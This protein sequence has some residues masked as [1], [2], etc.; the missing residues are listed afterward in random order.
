MKNILPLWII[1]FT[2]ELCGRGLWTIITCFGIS[3]NFDYLF[4]IL[5]IIFY[6]NDLKLNLSRGYTKW[7]KS[8]R[9]R[10]ISF[11][12]YVE[13]NKKWYKWSYL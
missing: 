9:E 13:S 1:F 6:V 12:L 4:Q 8:D 10:Q 11:H 3:H 2:N 7:S 5:H